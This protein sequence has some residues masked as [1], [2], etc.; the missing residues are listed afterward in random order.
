[1]GKINYVLVRHRNRRAILRIKDPQVQI[2]R[3]G[4]TYTGISTQTENVTWVWLV[5]GASIVSGQGTSQILV[6]GSP[7]SVSLTVTNV[8]WKSGTGTI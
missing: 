4:L 1:M 5:T 8:N 6:S 2:S 3:S 7:A